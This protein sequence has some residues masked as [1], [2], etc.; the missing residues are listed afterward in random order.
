MASVQ[1]VGECGPYRAYHIRP[2]DT[3]GKLGFSLAR[4]VEYQVRKM[5]TAQQTQRKVA[6]L[7]RRLD[8]KEREIAS[9]QHALESLRQRER[10]APG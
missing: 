7:R 3:A 6:D 5:R 1:D 4:Q 2:L 9:L 10:S 8:K